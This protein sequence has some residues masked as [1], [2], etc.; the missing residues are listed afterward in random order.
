MARQG[1]ACKKTQGNP[2]ATPAPANWNDLVLASWIKNMFII[3]YAYAWIFTTCCVF[4]QRKKSEKETTA[5][6]PWT[7]H[8]HTHICTCTQY[9]MIAWHGIDERA[10]CYAFT[11]S[12]VEL[13]LRCI[14]MYAYG[15]RSW[16]EQGRGLR[17]VCTMGVDRK[18]VFFFLF[19][20]LPYPPFF[21][22]ESFEYW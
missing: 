12:E 15:Y 22:P 2:N 16:G 11:S 1:M 17:A 21:F 7:P 18:F 8:S 14:C 10:C 20:C 5:S 9:I 6:R 4:S 13:V 19:L 3:S